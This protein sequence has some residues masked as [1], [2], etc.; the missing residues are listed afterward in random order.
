MVAY[1]KSG[2]CKSS[3]AASTGESRSRSG[4]NSPAAAPSSAGAESSRNPQRRTSSYLKLRTDPAFRR[5]VS[6]GLANDALPHPS[7]ST[8]NTGLPEEDSSW[9][10]LSEQE[11]EKIYRA[12]IRVELHNYL[13]A[14][15][16]D[17]ESS[18]SDLLQYWKVSIDDPKQLVDLDLLD[19][20]CV[21]K[22]FQIPDDV[23]S[24]SRY[25]SDPSLSRVL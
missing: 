19:G 9:A 1:Y 22:P 18:A 21:G 15:D 6:P 5:S 10:P 16:K 14:E 8:Q 4:M 12:V 11:Q 24:R 20:S 7:Q 17:M 13:K 2:L 3:P 25:P 23:S